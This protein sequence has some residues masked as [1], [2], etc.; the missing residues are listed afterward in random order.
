M[1]PLAVVDGLLPVESCLSQGYIGTFASQSLYLPTTVS[2]ECAFENAVDVVLEAGTLVTIPDD[3]I[4]LMWINE[5]A[6]DDELLAKLKPENPWGYMDDAF[7]SVSDDDGQQVL[8]ADRSLL[9]YR[10]PSASLFAFRGHASERFALD[11]VL[12][13]YHK[14]YDIPYP[15]IPLV[16]VPAD[17]VARVSSI[18]SHLKYNRTV[19]HLVD[20]LSIPQM[21]KDITWLTGEASDSPIESRHSFHPD[22]RKA[23][24]WILE[25]MES[26]GATCT[27]RPFLTGFTPNVIWYVYIL[28]WLILTK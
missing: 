25:Q 24:H 10:T 27:L 11:S 15:P 3:T 19:A 17:D 2:P 6:L 18:L 14:A 5:V 9:L 26:S 12:A 1:Q 8:S 7:R 4:S 20:G 16:P 13:S 21:H 22:A 23:A 28:F